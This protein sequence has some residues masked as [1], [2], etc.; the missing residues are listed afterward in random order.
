[1]ASFLDTCFNTLHMNI[2]SCAILLEAAKAD[3]MFDL[4]KD[5]I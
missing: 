3:A 5:L 4:V 1:M 2:Q